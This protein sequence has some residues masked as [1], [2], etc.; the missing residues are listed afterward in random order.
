[1]KTIRLV[2]KGKVQGVFFRATAKEVADGLGIKGWVRNLQ[3][4]NVEI[5]ATA[6]DEQL[7]QLINWCKQ[8]PPR[9]I[10]NEVIIEDAKTE[11]VTGFRIIR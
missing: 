7:T 8:G 10:V 1:M 4:N 11:L 6:P 5:V 2:I 9:A 3:D